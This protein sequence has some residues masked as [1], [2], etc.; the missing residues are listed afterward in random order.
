MLD[1]RIVVKA[2]NELGMPVVFVSSQMPK[3]PYFSSLQSFIQAPVGGKDESVKSK[4]LLIK[5]SNSNLTT[6]QQQEQPFR[7]LNG[8]L[9]MNMGHILSAIV[10]INTQ[11]VSFLQHVLH[12]D[13]KLNLT[14]RPALKHHLM[15][16]ALQIDS[17]TGSSTSAATKGIPPA[18]MHLH[19]PMPTSTTASSSSVVPP[20]TR[21]PSFPSAA[22]VL[23]NTDGSAVDSSYAINGNVIIIENSQSPARLDPSKNTVLAPLSAT[24]LPAGLFSGPKVVKRGLDKLSTEEGMVVESFNDV[25]K[26]ARLKSTS[27]TKKTLYLSSSPIPVT[28]SKLKSPLF[29]SPAKRSPTITAIS[30]GGSS[31]DSPAAAKLFPTIYAVSG[32]SELSSASTA[33]TAADSS[34][35]IQINKTDAEIVA[36]QAFFE[37]QRGMD[38][39]MS[40]A[41]LD[42][43]LDTEK[44][45]IEKEDAVVATTTSTTHLSKSPKPS[46]SSSPSVTS[47]S[48]TTL[49]NSTKSSTAVLK[50]ARPVTIKETASIDAATSVTFSSIN[51]SM[52]GS[53][54]FGDKNKRG[55]TIAT[56]PIIK[57]SP[58]AAIK[59]ALVNSKVLDG[60]PTHSM[61][62]IAK[63]VSSE[64]GSVNAKIPPLKPLSSSSLSSSSIPK[65][66]RQ[67][68]TSGSP[69]LTKS[70]V[71][72]NKHPS[73]STTATS[74][75]TPNVTFSTAAATASILAVTKPVTSSSYLSTADNTTTLAPAPTSTTPSHAQTK[76]T[77]SSVKYDEQISS[78]CPPGIPMDLHRL[79][80]KFKQPLT[81]FPFVQSCLL[82]PTLID[83]VLP[84]VQVKFILSDK[85][86][87][88]LN[89]SGSSKDGST[90]GPRYRIILR[91]YF[92]S[93][94]K[95]VSCYE[96]E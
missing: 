67:A 61:V 25:S 42:D 52:V 33:T 39:V 3:D 46:L 83:P 45:K 4:V 30:P 26:R 20:L 92:L 69:S 35:A 75:S 23:T 76:S 49:S 6:Q 28:T 37:S 50:D 13:L 1:H 24:S 70:S 16:W 85:L 34:V 17:S 80:M 88:R 48:S 95:Q 15:Q 53:R 73:S 82:P 51:S 18:A 96:V 2:I 29:K 9:L 44:V 93:N 54:S 60:S 55:G 79:V 81:M 78:S 21:K 89:A 72:E 57:S 7:D 47:A 62:L 94:P 5:L 38:V 59:L 90:D 63:P 91:G 84:E 64:F 8:L 32:S 71:Q 68:L 10:C 22:N 40:A 56:T 31:S 27:P 14:K 36:E 65:T 12:Q 43:V 41:D 77:D 87:A 19:P 58:A 86:F 11:V 66:S 74:L